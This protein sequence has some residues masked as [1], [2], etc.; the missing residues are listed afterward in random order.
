MKEFSYKK[1]VSRTLN[2]LR[3]AGDGEKKEIPKARELLYILD[4]ELQQEINAILK[5]KK[6]ASGGVTNLIKKHNERRSR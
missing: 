4:D 6:L 2:L 5:D 1:L 3:E